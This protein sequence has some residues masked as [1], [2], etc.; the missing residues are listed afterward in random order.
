[1]KQKGIKPEEEKRIKDYV[2]EKVRFNDIAHGWDHV[3]CVVNIAKRIGSKEGANMRILIP[4]AYF[5]DLV[6]RKIVAEHHEHSKASTQEAKRFLEKIGFSKRETELIIRT[7]LTASYEAHEKGVEPELLEAK[8]LRDADFL[9]AMGARGI[10]RVFA[11][12]GAYGCPRGLGKLEWDPKNPPKLKMNLN[13]P[14]PSAI[15]HFASK[16]LWLKDLIFT[17]EGKKLA[18][19]RHEFMIKFLERYKKEMEGVL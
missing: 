8:V 7:I 18:K 15:Y 1:M 6:P 9:D 16:L 17:R 12:A 10:A 14:D 3:E 4:A 5:H 13:G 2:R 19:E 11:F